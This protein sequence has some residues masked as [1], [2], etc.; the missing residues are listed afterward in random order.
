MGFDCRLNL[1]EVTSKVPEAENFPTNAE[2]NPVSS[3][4]LQ[5]QI[6]AHQILLLHKIASW[7]NI[8]FCISGTIA[9]CHTHFDLYNSVNLL[10][11]LK[12]FLIC[13]K[14]N[15][16]FCLGHFIHLS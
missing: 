13:Y 15:V 4:L 9:G 16:E 3:S 12:K 1:L 11:S 6:T 2:H 8:F 5:V 14:L 7:L 10:L